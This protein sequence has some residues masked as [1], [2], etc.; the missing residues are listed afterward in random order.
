M[1]YRQEY[2][3]LHKDNPDIFTGTCTYE[4]KDRIANL[5][6]LTES[7]TV[8]DYGCGKA[9]QYKKDRYDIYWGVE[10]DL[11][12]PGVK[13]Y[14]VLPD[15]KYDGIVC[16]YVMEHVPEEEVDRVLEEIFSRAEKFVYMVIDG[17]VDKKNFSDGSPM[18]V[19]LKTQE[20]WDEKIRQHNQKKILVAGQL[21]SDFPR[22]LNLGPLNEVVSFR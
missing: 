10:V 16:I 13:E 8:L 18:H 7:D 1:K 6:S 3:D 19:C 15:K 22:D 2:I 21:V 11:Y 5:I 20:W 9:R 14:S 12:D 17:E 4:H